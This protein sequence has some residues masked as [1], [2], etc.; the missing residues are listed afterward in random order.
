VL[1]EGNH[2]TAADYLRELRDTAQEALREMRLLIFNC[3]RLS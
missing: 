2:Q 3:A 1:T